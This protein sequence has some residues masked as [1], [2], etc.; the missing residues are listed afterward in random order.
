MGQVIELLGV[1]FLHMPNKLDRHIMFDRRRCVY[2]PERRSAQLSI[3][4]IG[5]P[6]I[7][8]YMRSFSLR[9]NNNYLHQAFP[10]R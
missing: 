6:M 8:S 2:D 4:Y 3:I 10:A 9:I 1:D 7:L 5:P